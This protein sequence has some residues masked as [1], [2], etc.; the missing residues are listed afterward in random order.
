MVL[1]VIVAATDTTRSL[2]GATLHAF[3]EHPDQFQ[4]LRDRPEL[5]PNAVEEVL[6]YAL[7]GKFLVRFAREE[8]VL[9]GK[10]IPKG[11]LVLPSIQ[12]ASRDPE[13]YPDP[14]R[15]D[16]ERPIGR[17]IVFGHGAHYCL[18]AALAR[19]E[20]K[21]GLEEVIKRFPNITLLSPPTTEA[22]LLLRRHTSLRVRL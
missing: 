3:L 13:V 16:I 12:A 14:D 9:G 10:V 15:F 5:M 18:G 8:V 6:R 2:L 1:A 11:A 19:M 22:N 7:P 17:T 20:I 4:L 21:L